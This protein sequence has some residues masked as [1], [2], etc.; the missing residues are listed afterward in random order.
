MAVISQ[1]GSETFREYMNYMKLEFPLIVYSLEIVDQ[2]SGQYPK[3][4]DFYIAQF[5]DGDQGQMAKAN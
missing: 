5:F 4:Q 3:C 2:V 1:I